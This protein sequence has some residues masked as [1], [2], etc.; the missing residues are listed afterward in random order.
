M[1][2]IIIIHEPNAMHISEV[3]DLETMTSLATFD[4]EKKCT[5]LSVLNPHI[6]ESIL[7]T[8]FIR[9]NE[10]TRLDYEQEKTLTNVGTDGNGLTFVEYN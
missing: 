5:D 3:K 8:H 10:C 1:L 6:G 9:N 4:E 2:Q 7:V